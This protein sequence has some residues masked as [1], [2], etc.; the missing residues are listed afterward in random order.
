MTR[1]ALP[2]LV[3]EVRVRGWQMA[4]YLGWALSYTQ[5]WSGS[6][7][8]YGEGHNCQYRGVDES[9][10]DDNLYITGRLKIEGLEYIRFRPVNIWRFCRGGK[11]SP[12]ENILTIYLFP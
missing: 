8:L 11:V 4:W 2:T 1:L 10:I 3:L 6:S 9:L 7:P 12:T 5:I